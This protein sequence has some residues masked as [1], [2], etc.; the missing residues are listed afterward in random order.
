MWYHKDSIPSR[1][2]NEVNLFSES[3]N[4]FSC[5]ENYS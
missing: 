1:R 5:V 4:L 3:V 2:K